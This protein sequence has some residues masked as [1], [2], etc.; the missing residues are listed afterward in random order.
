MGDTKKLKILFVGKFK[1]FY[2]EEYIARSFEML[3]HDVIRMEQNESGDLVH[4]K[5]LLCK[6]DVLLFTKYNIPPIVKTGIEKS[7]EWGMVTVC[8]LFDL[9]WGYIREFRIK[10][11]PYFKADFVFTTDGG[12]QQRWKD[13]GV[14]HLC[15]RQGIWKEDCLLLERGNEHDVIFVGSISPVY[16]E[17]NTMMN[18]VAK[19]YHFKW[20]GR[21]DTNEIRG[22]D[23]NK[24][25]ART[26]IVIG[27]SVYAP[28]YWS[29]R[30]VETLGRGGFLIHRD[31]PGIKEE[32]PYLVTY[33]GSF[34]NLCE[35]IDYYLEH[36]E[37]RREIQ[38]KN[39]EWVKERYTMDKKCAELIS[40]L[41]K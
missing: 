34:E 33:D 2:D 6:P 7:R 19:K 24:V 38:K 16:P 32:Y 40:C 37:E 36:D 15:V 8:W 9:Y 21:F 28:H 22:Q 3:G 13:V 29:N 17:R 1:N 14:N 12:D 18:M 25:Y 31:V 5:I 11:D 10:N 4:R 30:V 41:K 26:K 20:Y 39:F 23:L 27:D 35:K